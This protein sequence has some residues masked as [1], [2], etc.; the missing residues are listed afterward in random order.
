MRKYSLPNGT[1]DDATNGVLSNAHQVGY[2]TGH[3]LTVDNV[4]PAS[5]ELTK[6]ITNEVIGSSYTLTATAP[7]GD[8][9]ATM[10]EVR[11]YGKTSAEGTFTSPTDGHWIGTDNTTP[12]SSTYTYDWDPVAPRN[13]PCSLFLD[14]FQGFS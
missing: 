6:P 5:C 9:D 14:F 13:S 11:W 7:S 8:A 10:K 12:G 2:G 4:A 1:A 3:Y